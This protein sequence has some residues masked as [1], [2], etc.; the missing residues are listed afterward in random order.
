MRRNA[1]KTYMYTGSIIIS[2]VCFVTTICLLWFTSNKTWLAVAVALMVL[3]G[4]LVV[5][6]YFSKERASIYYREI[7]NKMEQTRQG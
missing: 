6:D 5:I 2:A 4:A 3:G 7:L 1:W